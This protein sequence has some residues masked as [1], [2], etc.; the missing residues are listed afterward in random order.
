M[1][2]TSQ[3]VA[4]M[5]LGLVLRL[6]LCITV[7]S[8]DVNNHVEWG[9]SILR[10]GSSGAYDRHYRGVMQ[11]TYPPLAL[12]AFTTSYWMYDSVYNLSWALN[13]TTPVFPSAI[14]WALEDQDV[15]P[16]FHKAVSIIS[17]LGI[18]V[19]IYALSRKVF[20]VSHGAG[21]SAAAIFLFNPAI[22]Y[23]SA[24]WGQMESPPIFWV[25]LSIWL[26]LTKRPLLGHSAFIFAMLFK[27]STLIF[28]PLILLLSLFKSGWKKTVVGL[29]LQVVIFVVSYLPFLPTSNSITENIIYPFSVYL[30]RIEV[31]SGSNYISDHAFNLWA[32]FTHLEKIPD[33][34]IMFSNLTAN[35][36][37]KVLFI[38]ISGWFIS[39]Y[40]ISRSTR[41]LLSL[42][43][44]I[45]FCSFMVLTRMH[46]RYLAPAIP[47]LALVSASKKQLRPIFYLVSAGHLIN[48]YHE[49]WFPYL[50][51]VV[52]IIAS[53]NTIYFV[54]LLFTISWISWSAVYFHDPKRQN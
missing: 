26:F 8:G 9:R 27:Q 7:Y 4:L 2:K 45:S 46:E 28:T 42:F 43:G 37:G 29:L 3:L 53:W 51:R 1:I 35:L 12:Y 16:A 11:P 31:G 34:I 40:L 22:F 24:L 6:A 21:L 39:K 25:M 23:N 30:H 32:L 44:L 13:K 38:V 48:L 54:I 20:S 10:E 18:A 52:P 15:L 33:S 47:F 19:L 36:F 14:I 41:D 5:F 49:W 50:D 17:D